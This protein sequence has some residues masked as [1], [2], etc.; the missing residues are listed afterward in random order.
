M[1]NMVIKFKTL[2]SHFS[3]NLANSQEWPPREFKWA[4]SRLS[5]SPEKS[6]FDRVAPYSQ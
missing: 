2:F 3:E 1:K 4:N 6:W 5:V